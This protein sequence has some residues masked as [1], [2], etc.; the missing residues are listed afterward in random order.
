MSVR[1]LALAGKGVGSQG[2]G[3][4][5]LLCGS[6][7]EQQR[8]VELLGGAEFGFDAF[9][10]TIPASRGAE[11]PERTLIG[12]GRLGSSREEQNM[13]SSFHAILF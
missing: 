13:L 9:A 3:S 11:R 1:R 5:Q 10:L 4:M 2:D 6:A 7:E 8:V 12:D